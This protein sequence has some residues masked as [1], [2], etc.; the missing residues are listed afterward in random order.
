[1][2]EQSLQMPS[3]IMENLALAMESELEKILNIARERAD[4][5][6]TFTHDDERISITKEDFQGAT[7]VYPIMDPRSVTKQQKMAKAQ[8]VYELGMNNPLIAQNPNSIYIITKQTLESMEV[9]DIDLIL[10]KPED[11][12]PERIDDQ[13]EE[14]MF[15]LMP[16]QEKPLF[17]VF[18]DQD[19]AEHIRIINELLKGFEKQQM[20]TG[21][22]DISE[23]QLQAIMMH[24][25]KH[26]AFLYGQKHG[27]IPNGQGQLGVME[28]QAGDE[29]LLAALADE[30]QLGGQSSNMS[31][32][33]GGAIPG[34]GGGFEGS[35]EL[36]GE[37]VLERVPLDQRNTQIAY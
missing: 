33:E 9:Q 23:E 15:F 12:K 26:V 20:G 21:K 28:A 31:I 30:L 22:M 4:T 35:G 24:K 37:G 19:H 18:P 17:D 3:S 1:M 13:H 14:N 25:Q 6:Q 32:G 29:A 34:T 36:P 2:L 10:P 27:V 7:R 5:I 8:S 11:Q 16:P